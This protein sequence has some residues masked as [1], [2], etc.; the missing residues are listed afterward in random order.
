MKNENTYE[1]GIKMYINKMF[2]LSLNPQ[3]KANWKNFI[4][5]DAWN[6]INGIAEN[7]S[8]LYPSTAEGL[9]R[10]FLDY[11]THLIT[12]KLSMGLSMNTIC[13]V[14]YHIGKAI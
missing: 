11:G 6:N 9:R 14:K 1:Y 8:P 4:L 5:K 10:L 12:K 13:F 2:A 3:A 7:E